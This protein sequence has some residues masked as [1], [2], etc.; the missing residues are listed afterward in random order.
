[1]VPARS[2]YR[3]AMRCG[4]DLLVAERGERERE[5]HVTVRVFPTDRNLRCEGEGEDLL[6]GR[7]VPH[8]L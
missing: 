6:E 5:L 8:A 4:F 7:E 1:M 2:D 3:D